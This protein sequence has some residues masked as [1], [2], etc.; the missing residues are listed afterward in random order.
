MFTVNHADMHGPLFI[1]S[2]VSRCF[3]RWR[4]PKP[5][6]FLKVDTVLALFESLSAG[7]Y[8]MSH[9]WD[10]VVLTHLNHFGTGVVF[11]HRVRVSG[12]AITGSVFR[13]PLLPFTRRVFGLSQGATSRKVIT[14]RKAQERAPAQGGEEP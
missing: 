11:V 2:S 1:I 9:F 3:E 14:A 8:S 12:S 5:L 6:C 7:S 4:I 13:S 10:G